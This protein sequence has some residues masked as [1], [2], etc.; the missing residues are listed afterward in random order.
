VLAAAG[1]GATPSAAAA[2]LSAGI[3]F[4]DDDFLARRSSAVYVDL[5]RM[6]EGH[7][8][9][10]TALLRA[11]DGAGGR[12]TVVHDPLV[13]RTIEDGV[14]SA[15]RGLDAIDL[16]TLDEVLDCAVAAADAQKSK[17]LD[18]TARCIALG[19]GSSGAC[20]WA[21]PEPATVAGR[22]FVHE[23]VR[24]LPGFRI[25]V[26]TDAQIRDLEAGRQM[27]LD[28]APN[29]ARSAFSHLRTVILGDFPH[30]PMNAL[31]VPG[32]PAV[33][34]LSPGALTG[35][36]AAVAETLLHES[37]HLKFLDIEYVTPLFPVGFRPYN[38]PRITPVWHENNPQFGG[39]PL[40]RLLTSLH[41]YTS[42]A[43]FFGVAADRQDDDFLSRDDCLARVEKSRMRAAW[44][45]GASRDHLEHFS[46]SGREF[47]AW[48][49]TM[50]E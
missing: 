41:V 15:L 4:G 2:E 6:L 3:P 31:T 30:A 25:E 29:L 20:V 23:V 8:P 42:L 12:D 21:D 47:V 44:L 33:V 24:R 48:I 50:L 5:L 26:P 37:V 7:S 32:L 16:A 34:L 43:A 39:W 35:G 11:L 36:S 46:P 40:D 17:V 45:L 9:A 38:S 27:A 19:P 14:C 13:R 10:A 28:V 22:R 49:G 18:A 1:E